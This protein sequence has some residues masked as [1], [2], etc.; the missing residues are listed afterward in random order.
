MWS[1]ERRTA[2][3]RR[4]SWDAPKNWAGVT[5]GHPRAERWLVPTKT[6]VWEASVLRH[7][8][9]TTA[10][11]SVARCIFCSKPRQTA[12]RLGLLPRV[13]ARSAPTRRSA[14]P[15]WAVGFGS[16]DQ[17]STD[18]PRRT[19]AKVVYK[20]IGRE[21]VAARRPAAFGWKVKG[22]PTGD[23]IL[24]YEDPYRI[25][26][27][28]DSVVGLPIP[29]VPHPFPHI[30][31]HIVEPPRVRGLLLD[32][33]RPSTVQRSFCGA[34][35]RERPDGVSAV[36]A[37]LAEIRVHLASRLRDRSGVERGRRSRS[38]RE[39]PLCLGRQT[40]ASA[41]EP[42]WPCGRLLRLC[43][44]HVVL[45]ISVEIA[46]HEA[47]TSR[48]CIT[49]RQRVIPALVVCGAVGSAMLSARANRRL[50]DG[51]PLTPRHLR[52]FQPVW[53]RDCHL[54]QGFG[55]AAADLVLWASH[56]ERPGLDSNPPLWGDRS[57]RVRRCDGSGLRC[58]LFQP[59][60]RLFGKMRR[61]CSHGEREP[62]CH[63]H[64]RR[65]T[66]DRLPE[67]A[68]ARD[69]RLARRSDKRFRHLL[70]LHRRALPWLRLSGN[71]L[72]RPT[73]W[74]SAAG[75]GGERSEP[76]C[77]VVLQA[78]VG[79]PQWWRHALT[80]VAGTRK[81]CSGGSRAVRGC[82]RPLLPGSR[83]PDSRPRGSR[84]PGRLRR[85]GG[86]APGAAPWSTTRRA[87]RARA[88]QRRP[89]R[90]LSGIRAS[91][92]RGPA[93]PGGRPGPVP[94]SCTPCPRCSAR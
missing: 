25:L 11:A 66:R 69:R 34:V 80:G 86:P 23:P 62:E 7:L 19:K 90:G 57:G 20:V 50:R 27:C 83:P 91:P 40:V 9:A 13:G 4:G 39:L 88:D 68:W 76:P 29:G 48:Q 18:R 73:P 26:L 65:C 87:G 60:R 10:C 81:P 17:A 31:E 67:E 71:A 75:Y 6:W 56:L 28:C 36:P 64:D 22:A 53:A 92:L 79:R 21:E 77:H 46:R 72:I 84:A 78:L 35:D 54:M 33:L 32:G 59:Y 45:L 5:S 94:A 74:A 38:R 14:S 2:A 12:Q 49:V 42:H 15:R 41:L 55:V 8:S 16:T 58:R 61:A 44:L 52:R 51:F 89:G 37:R 47:L 43:A 70:L 24:A 85:P 63:S 1:D 3:G 82:C 93:P 30:P